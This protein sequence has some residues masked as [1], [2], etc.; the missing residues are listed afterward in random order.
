MNEK[1]DW[2]AARRQPFADVETPDDWPKGVR[3]MSW[4]GINLLGADG[5][6]GL[7]WDGKKVQTVTRLGFVER[8][9]ATAVAVGTVSMAIFDAVRYIQGT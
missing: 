9:L 6:G 1:V 2:D 7:Y 3:P 4:Q 8:A 5:V